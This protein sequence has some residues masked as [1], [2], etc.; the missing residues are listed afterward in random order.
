M[1]GEE[2]PERFRRSASG[3]PRVGRLR[4][5]R[6]GRPRPATLPFA[7]LLPNLTTIVGLCA[8]LTAIRFAVDGRHELAAVLIIFS[9]LIDGLDG[10]L[11]R[12]LDAASSFGAE[13]DSLSDFVCFGVAPGILVFALA[14]GSMTGP[15]WVFVLVY[16][17]GCCLRLARFNVGRSG[18]QPVGPPHFIGVPAPAGA[19][20]ALLPA[21]VTFAGFGDA[22]AAP[23]LVAP[24]LGLV[25]IAMV[26]RI[27]T[28]SPKGLRVPRDRAGWVLIAMAIVVG[29]ALTR[30][31]PMMVV[32]VVAYAAHVVY[33]GVAAARAATRGRAD[34]D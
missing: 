2:R 30:F 3:R 23:A 25:G 15:G 29:V 12:R 14:L 31:W 24:Y 27:R 20:L 26:S 16:V 21:F 13:L 8:G 5:R 6:P 4:V 18:P 9:A 10:L 17:I 11:A 28:F 33:G 7:H 1:A 34:G 22:A 32:V 19:M